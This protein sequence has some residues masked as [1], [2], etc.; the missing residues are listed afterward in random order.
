M[1]S[2]TGQT[3]GA[4]GRSPSVRRA[5][6]EITSTSIWSQDR[7]RSPSVRRAWI[8]MFFIHWE[9][10]QVKKSPSV[11]RAWIEIRFGEDLDEGELVALREEGVD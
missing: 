8:E 3:P 1:K 7:K 11:R 6:I 10:C 5:W 2:G 4:V 9:V